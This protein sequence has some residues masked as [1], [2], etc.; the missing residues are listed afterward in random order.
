MSIVNRSRLDP[1][2]GHFPTTAAP[3]GMLGESVDLYCWREGL[4]G[5]NRSSR[6]RL[7]SVASCSQLSSVSSLDQNR[8]YD[9][10]KCNIFRHI[11]DYRSVPTITANGKPYIPIG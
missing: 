1:G 3:G 11:C 9:Y 10:H 2:L 4:C 8:K 5:N 7:V 6:E